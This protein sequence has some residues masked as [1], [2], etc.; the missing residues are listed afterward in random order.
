MDEIQIDVSK[1]ITP[2]TYVLTRT[3]YDL[4]EPIDLYVCEIEE[5]I[6]DLALQELD[7][8]TFNIDEQCMV[9]KNKNALPCAQKDN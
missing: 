4:E 5:D 7:G 9:E 8:H 6:L 1:Q 3:L 2:G